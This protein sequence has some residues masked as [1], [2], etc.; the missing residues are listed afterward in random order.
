MEPAEGATTEDQGRV[1]LNVKQI[2]SIVPNAKGFNKQGVHSTLRGSHSLIFIDSMPT[3]CLELLEVH[4]DCTFRQ[5]T[6]AVVVLLVRLRA[7]CSTLRSSLP[8]HY[9]TIHCAPAASAAAG[10]PDQTAVCYTV[11]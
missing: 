5:H 8:L 10:H 7:V 11:C 6:L 4:C 1:D 3:N 9:V 2:K